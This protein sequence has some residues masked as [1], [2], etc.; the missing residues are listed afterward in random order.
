[1][2][3]LSFLSSNAMLAAAELKIFFGNIKQTASRTKM[4]CS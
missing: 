4:K 1:M 3:G 2:S